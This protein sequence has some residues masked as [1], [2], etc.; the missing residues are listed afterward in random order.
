MESTLFK[1][2]SRG[3]TSGVLNGPITIVYAAGG[4]AIILLDKYLMPKIKTNKIIKLIISFIIYSVVLGLIEY[5]CGYLC[6]IIFGIDMWNYK[7][8][9]YHIGKYTCL[10]YIPIWGLTAIIITNV[11]KPYINKIIKII[12]REFTYFTSLIFVL[13]FLITILTK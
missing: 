7:D 1:N 6:N 12:P 10:E 5:I 13:D 3:R 9:K 2:T 4:I 8:K 11:L